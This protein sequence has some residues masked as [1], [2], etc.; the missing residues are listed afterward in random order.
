MLTAQEIARLRFRSLG[1]A[2]N[3]QGGS[4]NVVRH[5][6]AMQAQDLFQVCWAVGQRC[7]QT[8]AQVEAAL[9]EGQVV[10]SW[11]MRSTLH[12]V[13]PEDLGWLLALTTDR[14]IGAAAARRR[15]RLG[16]DL[17]T[18]ERVRGI[19]EVALSGGNALTRSEL[20]AQVSE[21]GVELGPNW[22][23]HLTWYLA[24]TGTLV[25]GPT[26]AGEPLLVLS[27]EWLEPAEELDRD[28]ALRQLA[29]RFVGSRGPVTDLDLARWIGLPLGQVRLGLQAAGTALEQ[30]E[31]HDGRTY[32][33][34]R[35]AMDS[36]GPAIPGLAL[37]A[38]FDE[39]ILGYA[40]RSAQLP[41]EYAPKVCPGNSGVFRPT[42]VANGVTI[43][44]WRGPARSVVAR[45]PATQPLS[46]NLA[47]FGPAL[48]LPI[49]TQAVRQAAASHARFLGRGGAVVTGLDSPIEASADLV[50]A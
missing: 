1:L 13:C 29:L 47:P 43:G 10:R 31:G 26:R 11:P 38:A 34:A 42:M 36:P 4:A 12:L 28:E 48:A 5:L 14:L 27:S 35:Q 37:L 41:V 21:A 25:W 18:I 30:V 9:D 2:S 17:P 3:A 15:Q 8:L 50:V 20:F 44:T 45:V 49:T 32:W 22:S 16:L 33:L 6:L 7:G 19:V 23:Y 24:Q 40:D 39:H 46:V